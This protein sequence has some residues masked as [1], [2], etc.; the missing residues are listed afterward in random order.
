MPSYSKVS[1]CAV[2][3]DAFEYRGKDRLARRNLIWKGGRRLKEQQEDIK[4]ISKPW[5]R[6]RKFYR[7]VG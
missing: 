2:E 5:L 3:E 1:Q 7:K 6:W 4:S